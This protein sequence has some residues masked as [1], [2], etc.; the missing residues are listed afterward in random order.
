M[1]RI[2]RN[3][4]LSFYKNISLDIYN[5]TKMLNFVH[6]SFRKLLSCGYIF[7]IMRYFWNCL[8]TSKTDNSTLNKVY[9]ACTFI[10]PSLK[11][12]KTFVS[13]WF[14]RR[15]QLRNSS[16]KLK[17][18]YKKNNYNDKSNPDDE[19]NEHHNQFFLV[20]FI[21]ICNLM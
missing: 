1:I 13:N 5:E 14:W 19:L 16:E 10:L 15:K 6:C 12:K 2:N 11:I 7:C 18:I 21:L 4:I 17:R 3:Y 8:C 20:I 9:Y